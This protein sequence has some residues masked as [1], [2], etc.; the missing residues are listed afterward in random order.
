MHSVKGLS[1]GKLTVII[2][3]LAEAQQISPI[4]V[5]DISN[6]LYSLDLKITAAVEYF[7]NLAA[8]GLTI[9]PV[10]DNGIRSV[11]HKRRRFIQKSIY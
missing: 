8:T 5:I 9:S 2:R 7:T 4:V 1:R 6:I 11:V 3:G 10:C